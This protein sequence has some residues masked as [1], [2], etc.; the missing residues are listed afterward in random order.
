MVASVKRSVIIGFCLIV[1][2]LLAMAGVA[3][4][5]AENPFTPPFDRS[6]MGPLRG[7][8]AVYLSLVSV[9]G[10]GVSIQPQNRAASIAFFRRYYNVPTDAPIAWTGN[11]A[12]CNSGTIAP[13]FQAAMLRR[14]VYFRAMAGVPAAITLNAEYSAKAQQ[15]ALMMSANDTLSHSPSPD[16][17]CY[18][19]GG[20]H[21]AASGNLFL[22]VDG[23][24]AITGYMED[25]GGGNSAVGHRRWLL[26]PQTRSMGIG[27][28]PETA[29]YPAAHTL[30]LFDEYLFETRPATR[31]AFVAWPP[32][33]YVP[34]QVIFPRWSFSYPDADF[35]AATVT[36][37]G[38]G[39]TIAVAVLPI[40][41]GFG[42]NT[43]VWEPTLPHTTPPPSDV[44]YTVTIQNVRVG[45]A[46][47][48][49]SYEVIIVNPN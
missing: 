24:E 39:Q 49:F 27:D 22:G 35:T 33:G 9:A 10:N 16:W 26:Y 36:L 44:R 30:W 40:A 46:S 6:I 19:E 7:T 31:E 2:M 4:L 32:P 48:D 15:A 11:H 25:S 43:L 13:A 45:V 47:Q 18:T 38:A 1:A 37:T 17:R 42:E 20:S 5:R 29:D 41:D 12:Q 28:I 34:Y 8:Y 21:A 23:V 3:P 14:I